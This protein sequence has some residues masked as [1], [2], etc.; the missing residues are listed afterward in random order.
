MPTKQYYQELLNYFDKSFNNDTSIWSRFAQAIAVNPPIIENANG[1]SHSFI[2]TNRAFRFAFDDSEVQHMLKDDCN[3]RLIDVPFATS[4][5]SYATL[6]VNSKQIEL[7]DMLNEAMD[8]INIQSVF[9][10]IFENYQLEYLQMVC[11]VN[12]ILKIIP[13]FI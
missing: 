5:A 6:M 13:T 8:K 4:G 11:F 10:R 9:D 2:R 7:I 3:L 12:F 1:T